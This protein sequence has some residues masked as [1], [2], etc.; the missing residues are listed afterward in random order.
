M[1]HSMRGKLISRSFNNMLS[2][3]SGLHNCGKYTGYKYLFHPGVLGKTTPK[4]FE[5]WSMRKK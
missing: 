4:K 1:K 2:S 5:A 3:V